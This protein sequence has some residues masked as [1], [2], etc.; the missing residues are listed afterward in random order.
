MKALIFDTGPIISLTINNLLWILEELKPRFNGEFYITESV[1]DE[2]I[3]KPLATKRFKFEA[4]QVK[5]LIERGVLTVIK[6]TKIKKKADQLLE[7]AN[8]TFYIRRHP[9]SAFHSGEMETLAAAI[10]IGMETIVVD[11]RITRMIIE[12]PEQLERRL[13]KKMHADVVVDK[14]RLRKFHETVKHLSLIRSIELV[15]V[16]FEIGLLNK[17][18]VKIPNA[19]KELLDSLLWAV[20]LNGC[21]VTDEEIQE[22]S[23]EIL[24]K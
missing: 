11:E 16:A 8:R 4:M 5:G 18:I 23:K 19:E 12:K 7:L 20:K 2:L 17:Y 24:K 15:A 3:T 21:S 22:I 1:I 9:I 10:E 13:E 6:D 14:N